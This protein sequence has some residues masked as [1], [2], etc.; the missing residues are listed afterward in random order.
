MDVNLMRET[1]TREQLTYA[2]VVDFGSH[3]DK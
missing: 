3:F 2:P 1:L